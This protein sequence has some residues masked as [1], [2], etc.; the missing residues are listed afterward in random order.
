M[1][2][3]PLS[4]TAARRGLIDAAAVFLFMGFSKI[5]VALSGLPDTIPVHDQPTP[6]WPATP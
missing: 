6:A 2:W 5:A 4:P 3:L 1:S